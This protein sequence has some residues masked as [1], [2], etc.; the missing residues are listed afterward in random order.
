MDS[1]LEQLHKAITAATED[2]SAEELERHP[3]GKWSTAEVL[4]HLCLT[5]AG[6]VKGMG[7]C[8]EA[9]KA[10]A[11]VP[12]WKQRMRIVAVTRLGYLPSG[13]EAPKGARPRGMVPHQLRAEIASRIADMDRVISECETRLGKR[14]K[15]VDHPIL[16]PLT[17][18]EWRRF[19]WVHGRHHVKQICKLRESRGQ[20]PGKGRG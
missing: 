7:R 20:R 9:D 14:T 10:L 3:P 2:M 19:H 16:G 8:L 18:G 5:Y 17:A 6:T 12:T 1:Y 13:R 4:E 15:V 11:S